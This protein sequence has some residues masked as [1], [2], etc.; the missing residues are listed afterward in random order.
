MV[1]GCTVD[2][3]DLLAPL[4]DYTGGHPVVAY[5]GP[6]QTVTTTVGSKTT[7]VELDGSGSFSRLGLPLEYAW[8]EQ[9]TLLAQDT[10]TP[11]LAF[12]VGD[13]SIVLTVRDSQGNIAADSVKVTV[14]EGTLKPQPGVCAA[15]APLI[16][17]AGLLA[18][19]ILTTPRRRCRST[20][21][22][23]S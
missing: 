18:V 2:V 21:R 16:V 6:D 15:A 19:T 11:K 13:H 3:G 1:A 7:E 10:A 23:T 4:A 12:D 14:V 17:G 5:A 22:R 8:T 20:D 9:G